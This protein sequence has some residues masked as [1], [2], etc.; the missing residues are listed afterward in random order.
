MDKFVDSAWF[1]R[2]VALLLALLLYISVNFAD[3]QL[4]KKASESAQENSEVITDVP[5][6]AYYDT[7]NLFVSGL[8]ETVEV[9][10]EGPN[11]IIESEKRLQDFELFVDLTNVSIGKHR[12]PIKYTGF[13]DKLNV[14]VQPETVEVLVEERVSDYYTVSPE[15]DSSMLA[16][17]Y[18]TEEVS[19]DPRRVQV[20]GSKTA[21][22]KIV[23]VKATFNV[24]EKVSQETAGTAKVQVLD[25][26]LNKLDVKVE[27]E[28]VQV[29][30][31][32]KNPSKK[33]ALNLTPTGSPPAG[34]T[35][36]SVSTDT[37]E[38]T[39]YGK[40][41]VIKEIE[42]L[43]IPV[44]V[45]SVEKNTTLNVPIEIS[46]GLNFVS[47]QT[48]KVKVTVEGSPKSKPKEESNA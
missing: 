45:S 22:S 16:E 43:N 9:E 30:I 4:N 18:Q 39:V 48:V 47:P 35:V 21:L 42:E 38:I 44:D 11:S 36:T 12:V 33:V 13:S 17:G 2:I 41:S 19:V 6:Q 25:K 15:F 40:E 24:E 26:D 1:V 32:V 10:L 27:P 28:T 46:E 29:S 14:T 31:S 20:T 3:L 37:E 5:V 34:V 8:P 7:E 23:Y